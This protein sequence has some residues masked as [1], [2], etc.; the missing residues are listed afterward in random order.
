MQSQPE[1]KEPERKEESKKESTATEPQMLPEDVQPDSRRFRRPSSIDVPLFMMQPFSSQSSDM[2]LKKQLRNE[3]NQQ[4][5]ENRKVIS[6]APTK[7]KEG[8][9]IPTKKTLTIEPTEW[10]TF[11]PS[12]ESP[13]FLSGRRSRFCHQPRHHSNSSDQK[14][15]IEDPFSYLL[16]LDD[17]RAG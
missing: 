1:N 17:E 10:L 12:P 4:T 13:H 7:E 5:E 3:P 2:E 8:K 11:P 6:D 15:V 9:D 14:S 16:S